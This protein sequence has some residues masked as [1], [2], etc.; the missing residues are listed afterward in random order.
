[1][2]RKSTISLDKKSFQKIRGQFAVDDTKS[3]IKSSV[4]SL[5]KTDSKLRNENQKY[6]IERMGQEKSPQEKTLRRRFLIFPLRVI[7]RILFIEV[8]KLEYQA[9]RFAIF[10]LACCTN[11][12]SLFVKKVFYQLNNCNHF[13]PTEHNVIL[14]SSIYSLSKQIP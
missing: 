4:F 8:T 1:M 6:N 10:E 9:I 14:T 5:K 13:T 3:L 12:S 11:F 7:K 2:F